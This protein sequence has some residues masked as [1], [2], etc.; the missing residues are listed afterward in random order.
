M[1]GSF[2]VDLWLAFT[3]SIPAGMIGRGTVVVGSETS[4]VSNKHV[5]MAHMTHGWTDLVQLV[6]GTYRNPV[7]GTG[8]YYVYLCT[9]HIGH[10]VSAEASPTDPR[11]INRIYGMFPGS[12]SWSRESISLAIAVG[13]GV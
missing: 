7:E 5:I 12:E 1:G 2:T 4:I 11:V 10:L 8:M 6:P 9:R 3:A 13:S